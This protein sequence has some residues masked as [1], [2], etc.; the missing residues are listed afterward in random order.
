MASR[1]GI[2]SIA[3]PVTTWEAASYTSPNS[4]AVA[5]RNA[6]SDYAIGTVVK[7]FSS[8]FASVVYSAYDGTN[9]TVLLSDDICFS[10][11]TMIGRV[12]KVLGPNA[13]VGGTAISGGYHGAGSEPALAFDGRL[14]SYFISTQVDTGVSGYAYLGYTFPTAKK[15]R[16][17]SIVQAHYA[18]GIV[19][20]IGRVYLQYYNGSAWSSAPTYDY[21][22]LWLPGV[23]E[24]RVQDA[25]SISST[26]WRLLAA[27]NV[28]TSSSYAGLGWGVVEL[29]MG[30]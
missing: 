13:C 25:H 7:D 6:T 29:Q 21:P 8:R 26:Q 14:D 1:S 5:G 15:I 20:G 4:V 10:G 2:S 22:L 12:T 18:A 11:M 9:T 23:P 17:F 16:W 30:E 24:M 27:A 19:A 28:V 3:Q